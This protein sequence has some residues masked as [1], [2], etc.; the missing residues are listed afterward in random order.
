MDSIE[1]LS[2]LFTLGSLEVGQDYSIANLTASQLTTLDDLHDLGIVYRSPSNSPRFYPTRLATTLNSD[3]NTSSSS[4]SGGLSLGGATAADQRGFIVVETNYRIYAYTTNPLRMAILSLFTKMTTQ[5]PN[6]IAGKLTK[7]SVQDAIARGITSHQII[8]Y[9]TTH[10]HPVMAMHGRS[11]NPGATGNN[12]NIQP[13]LPPTVVDQIRLW[14]IEGDRMTPTPGYLFQ[15][16][17]D[18]RQYKACL[19]HAETVGVLQWHDD[20][21]RVFFVTKYDQIKSFLNNWS[22]SSSRTNG[23]G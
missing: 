3:S 6:M 1:I 16:F 20:K 12:Q 14:Q 7:K 4:L 2:F 19:E 15:E 13:S 21:R 8:A 11:T 9:L 17:V 23:A 5:Y 18:E 22:T 10:A